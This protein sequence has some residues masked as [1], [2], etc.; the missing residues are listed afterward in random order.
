MISLNT[1]WQFLI[2]SLQLKILI[3]KQK[4]DFPLSFLMIVENFLKSMKIFFAFK[5]NILLCKKII[6]L[7][8]NI[9]SG[10][11]ELLNAQYTMYALTKTSH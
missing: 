11:L 1:D 7:N 10:I 4:F 8:E 9:I 3:L 2:F 6:F 5:I